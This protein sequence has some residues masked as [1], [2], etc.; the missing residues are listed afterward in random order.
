MLVVC[1]TVA[2]LQ[3]A[4]AG[5]YTCHTAVFVKVGTLQFALMH[6]LEDS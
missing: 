6:H 3:A 2:Q 5:P 1:A 4:S